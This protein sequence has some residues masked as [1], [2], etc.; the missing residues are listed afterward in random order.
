MTDEQ[1][2]WA[3]VDDYLIDLLVGEDEALTSALQANAAAG[4]PGIDVAPN[5]GKL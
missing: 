4:L 5:Q 3:A 1:P 2:T